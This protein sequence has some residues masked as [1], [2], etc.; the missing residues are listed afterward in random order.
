MAKKRT[1]KSQPPAKWRSGYERRLRED[2]DSKEVLYTYEEATY[3]IKLDIVGCYCARCGERDIVRVANYTPDFY[4]PEKD[5]TVEA[6]G[7]FDAKA[8]KVALAFTSQYPQKD[9][10]L[11]FQRNNWIS[12]KKAS[13]YGDWCDK[14]GIRWA[15]GNKIPTEWRTP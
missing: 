14:H 15:V 10:A 9:Y 5:L 6:K 8:R 11:L 3:R 1:L 4:F 7:K 12:G 2:L 13:R